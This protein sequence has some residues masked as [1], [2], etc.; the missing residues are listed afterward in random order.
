MLVANSTSFK[1]DQRLYLGN[2]AIHVGAANLAN[3]A[4]SGRSGAALR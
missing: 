1:G 2:A 3:V 4:C